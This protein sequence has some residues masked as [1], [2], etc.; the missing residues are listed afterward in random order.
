MWD[1]HQYRKFRDE[2]ARP[3]HDLLARVPDLPF[4]AVADLGC[5]PGDMTR[6]LADRWPRAR[7]TGV[8]LSPEMLAAAQEFALPG[9][10][11]F[12]RADAATWT[13]PAPLD[14][15][16]SNAAL[17]WIPDHETL[18]PRLAGQV[19]PGGV[20]AIQMPANAADPIH[21]ALAEAAGEGPWRAKL[22]SFRVPSPLREAR[23]YIETLGGLGFEVDAWTTTYSHLLPGRDPVLEW[24]R[25][26]ALRPVL[27]R[28]DGLERAEFEE[29]YG[30][31]L[32]RAYPRIAGGTLFPFPRFFFTA[33]RGRV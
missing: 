30:S 33:R 1:A 20:L 14:L 24:A 19:A 25:G 21:T 18:V 2:R 11:E 6:L 28:L 22:A 12:V 10:L 27:A 32:R 13:P 15:V 8:D 17:Q 7:I 16:I 5:G 3:F 29:A 9:R 23:W 31:K 26:S 4:A